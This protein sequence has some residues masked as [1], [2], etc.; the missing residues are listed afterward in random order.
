[1]TTTRGRGVARN[2]ETGERTENTIEWKHM[3]TT[4]EP[5]HVGDINELI[6]GDTRNTTAIIP[7][8]K[9]CEVCALRCGL[10][11]PGQPCGVCQGAKCV[12]NLVED[13]TH[14]EMDE[15]AARVMGWKKIGPSR[16]S[17]PDGK[18]YDIGRRFMHTSTSTLLPHPTTDANAAIALAM[19]VVGSG[20]A[21]IQFKDADDLDEGPRPWACVAGYDAHD[22]SPARALTIAALKAVQE[23][24][25]G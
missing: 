2:I 12:P 4:P 18:V 13:M 19:R 17:D 7:T 25:D 23:R 3:T 15:A 14:A 6:G 1:M 24:G 9:P 20:G 22:P 8:T 16:W 10:S 11:Y 5:D 21:V